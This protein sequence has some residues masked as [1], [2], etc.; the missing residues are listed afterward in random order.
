[1][2]VLIFYIKGWIIHGSCIFTD[3]IT[4]KRR[5]ETSRFCLN[6]LALVIHM[7]HRLL[8]NL[9]LLVSLLLMYH[10]NLEDH[11]VFDFFFFKH[12]FSDNKSEASNVV[13]YGGIFLLFI[14]K[15]NYAITKIVMSSKIIM[16]ICKLRI[17]KENII[18][19]WIKSIT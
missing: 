17:F 16:S 6:L 12:I 8:D 5:N 11:N 7:D 13:I 3:E 2:R 19:K 10:S 18:C 4:K 9:V 14:C 15:I 1:M